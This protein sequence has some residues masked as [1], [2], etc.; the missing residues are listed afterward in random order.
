MAPGR[1][2]TKIKGKRHWL[3]RAVDKYGVVLD[4]LIQQRRDQYA[5]ETFLRRVLAAAGSEPRVVITDKLASYPPA[6]RRVLPTTEH[7]RHKGLNNRAEN[8]HQPTRQ[9]E[10]AMRRFKSAE[11]AQRFL[12]PFGAVGDHFRTG[13]YRTPAN[14]RRQLLAERRGTGRLRTAIRPH[15]PARRV[16]RGTDHHL[17]NLTV[18]SQVRNGT[19]AQ[20]QLIWL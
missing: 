14:T 16:A 20:L 1:G 10:R 8:S 11:H 19:P 5:A 3:W 12:E 7:R 13:R 4:I 6:I 2:A 9:R 18:P 17:L 15:A